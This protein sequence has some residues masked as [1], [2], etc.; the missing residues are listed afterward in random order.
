MHIALRRKVKAVYIANL[1]RGLAGKLE[2]YRE[3]E[4]RGI[5]TS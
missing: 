1:A 4:E 3:G 5:A 2:R